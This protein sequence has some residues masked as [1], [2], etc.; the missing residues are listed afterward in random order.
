M[1][2]SWN[3]L[4]SLKKKNLLTSD[5]ATTISEMPPCQN[6]H[7]LRCLARTVY[8]TFPAGREAMALFMKYRNSVALT[9][10]LYTWTATNPFVEHM[11]MA[12]NNPIVLSSD[13]R[14]LSLLREDLSRRE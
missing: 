8:L 2:F 4:G 14:L 12:V 11:A 9:S 6:I 3:I 7:T 1:I 5:E 10:L 13:C